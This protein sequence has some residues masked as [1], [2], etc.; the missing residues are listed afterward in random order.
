MDHDQGRVGGAEPGGLLPL[1]LDYGPANCMLCTDDVEPDELLESGHV[2]AI[3]RKAVALGCPAADAVVMATLHPARYHGLS[4]LGAIA[5]GYLADI[6]AVPDLTS[7]R[8]ALVYKR[9]R[10]VA[11]G[12]ETG[13]DRT[14]RPRLTGCAAACT[15]ARSGTADLR[16][17]APGGPVRVIEVRPGELVD[18]DARAGR[19]R[20]ATANLPPTRA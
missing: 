16:I 15:C 19:R 1:V 7:F 6:V 2:N 18:P 10:L 5:P 4:E 11:A 9:G 12:R 3:L 14:A 17:P 13:R 20:S 8:P